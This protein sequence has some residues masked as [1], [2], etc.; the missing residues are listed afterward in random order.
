MFQHSFYDLMRISDAKTFAFSSENPTGTKGGG[1]RGNIYEKLNA[2]T[3]VKPGKTIALADAEGSGIIESMWLTGYTGWDFILRIYWDGQEYPSVETPLSA[4]FGYAFNNNITNVNNR[5]PA[6]N[7]AMVMAAPCRGL[8][9][10]WKMPFRKHCK[11]TLENRSSSEEHGIY[12]T[13]T[14]EYTKVPEDCA[15]FC[16]SYRQ[17]RPVPRDKA[18]TVIDGIK[19]RGHYVGLSLAV[20]LG[21]GNG[22]WVEGEPK[23][24]ID[25]DKYPTINYTGTED[26]FCGAYFFGKD[27]RAMNKSQ[28]YSG[29]YAGMFAEFGPCANNGDW[30]SG[31]RF[32][33]LPRFMLYRWHVPD[34]IRFEKDFR[35]T[36][37]SIEFSEYGNRI[38]H[39]EY[40][41]VAYWYQTLP[42]QKLAPLPAPSDMDLT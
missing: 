23:I 40:A 32:S 18:Y 13:I 14:G 33:K 11:I 1:S 2:Y 29:L 6:L 39:D 10:Y 5:F 25:G 28:E 8:S 36:L 3:T 42:T 9:C 34:P 26:Y 27:I 30:D 22:C 24:Y 16:A 21:G 37:Q 7:S 12:Y 31:E 15:Y 35:M 4:F 20:T 41:T 19:G 38:R 17:S